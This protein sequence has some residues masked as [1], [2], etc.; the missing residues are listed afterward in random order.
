MP[1]SLRNRSPVIRP[2]EGAEL[3]RLYRD[4][5]AAVQ[6]C[7]AV[8]QTHAMESA[9]FFAAHETE[10]AITRRIKEILGTT[11]KHWMA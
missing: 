6:R 7:L 2:E 5:E 11:S 9:E 10:S 4:K 3:Q 8:L 1:W